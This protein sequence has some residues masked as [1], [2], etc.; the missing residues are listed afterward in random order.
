M[1]LSELLEILENGVGPVSLSDKF[2]KKYS[3]YDNSGI[4]LNCCDEVKGVLFALDLSAEA[5]EETLSRGFNAIVTHHPAIY[6]G[7]SRLDVLCDPQSAALAEC[8]KNGV[9]VIS[10]HL[11]FDVAPKG[12]DY[13]LMRGLGGDKAEL[14]ATVEG[15]GYG[16]AYSV[17]PADFL[18]YAKSVKTAL[19]AERIFAYGAPDR[20][21]KRV[22]SFCGAGCDDRA[23]SF[24]YAEKADVF[25]SSDLKHHEIRALVSRGINVIQLTHYTSENYGFNKIYNEI[26][27]DLPVA[28]AYFN[29]AELA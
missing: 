21:I 20:V 9:S 22:A 28:S 8:L 4:I 19:G 12:I 7:L 25:V 11:N 16:R 15:G 5:V 29:D 27:L 23:V 26:A 6:G 17:T 3:M 10:M 14:L 18:A 1:K 24:A 13:H 2:C